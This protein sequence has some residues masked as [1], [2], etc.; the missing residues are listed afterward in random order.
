MRRPVS[1]RA[2]P[3]AVGPTGRIDL[4]GACQRRTDDPAREGTLV[5][6]DRFILSPRR[7]WT[8]VHVLLFSL[9]KPKDN[10]ASRLVR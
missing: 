2:I 1:E 4:R 9:V 7:S 10:G 5:P 8:N 3:G 6:G